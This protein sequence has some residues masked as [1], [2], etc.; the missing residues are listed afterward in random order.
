MTP[1]TLI[2]D[3]TKNAAT[4]HK[5]RTSQQSVGFLIAFFTFPCAFWTASFTSLNITKNGALGELDSR[6]V[7]SVSLAAIQYLCSSPRID[8]P[9]ICASMLAAICVGAPD[10]TFRTCMRSVSASQDT[11]LY[12]RVSWWTKLGLPSPPS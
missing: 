9:R 12:P 10:L 2:P 8:G 5:R 4:Y 11:A 3:S 7:A 1:A 6:A